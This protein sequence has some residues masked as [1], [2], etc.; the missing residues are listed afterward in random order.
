VQLESKKS[1]NDTPEG[2]APAAHVA[3]EVGTVIGGV[4]SPVMNSKAPV[5]VEAGSTVK[6]TSPKTLELDVLQLPSAATPAQY[7]SG[8]DVQPGCMNN[9]AAAI[10]VGDEG[11]VIPR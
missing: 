2:T 7:A 3:S 9:A 11:G 6:Y 4:K 5:A 10:P 1:P 8:L